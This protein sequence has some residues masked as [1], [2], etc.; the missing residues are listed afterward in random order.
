MIAPFTYPEASHSRKHGPDGYAAYESYRPW[1][2]DEFAFRCVF[3]LTRE[4]W[5]P[6]Q[7][8]FAID[9]FVPVKAHPSAPASYDNL[10]YTCITCN[11]AKSDRSVPDPLVVLHQESVWIDQDGY[12]HTKTTEAALTN[13][14]LD[15]NH[16]RKAEFRSLWMAVVTLSRRL[17]PATHRRILVFPDD[18]PNLKR[19]LPPNGNKWPAGVEL[20]YHSQRSRGKLPATY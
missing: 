12:L 9:H 16:P 20:S 3:C 14:L 18:L 8:Q 1:L 19:L 6:F 4:T 10:L 2:R 7:A 17:D 11:S 15:L 13:E 5:G